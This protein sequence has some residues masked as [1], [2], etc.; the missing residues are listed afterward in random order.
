MESRPAG[1]FGGGG[2][3]PSERG[4]GGAG[5]GGGGGGLAPLFFGPHAG[6]PDGAPGIFGRPRGMQL[7]K[8]PQGDAGDDCCNSKASGF[9]LEP[10]VMIAGFLTVRKNLF[11]RWTQIRVLSV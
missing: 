6:R 3:V 7:R 9:F 1:L 4:G 10:N 5:A 11:R 2:W 8:P